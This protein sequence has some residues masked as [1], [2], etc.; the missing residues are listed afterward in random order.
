MLTARKASVWRS[1]YQIDADGRAVATWDGSMW[2]SGGDFQLDGAGYRVR[3]NAWGTRYAMTAADGTPVAS[4]ERVGRK[5]W[6]VEAGGQVY[7]FQRAS[8]W[9]NVQELH[10]DAGP[11]GS[12]RR[13]ST[14][15]SDVSADL[16]GL[17]LPVQIFVVGVVITMWEA[18]STVAAAG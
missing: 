1:R 17:P 12:V 13:T 5:R 2:R 3:S 7:R 8:V 16:P 4:A 11:V 15:R 9:G 18:Q 14:W 10:G 6:T